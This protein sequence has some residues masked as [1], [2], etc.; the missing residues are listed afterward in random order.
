MSCNERKSRFLLLDK[1]ED[2]TATSFNEALVPG[3]GVLPP[4]LRRPSEDSR[5]VLSSFFVPFLF[6]FHCQNI[7]KKRK[8][9]S[10][11]TERKQMDKNN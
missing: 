6:H 9:W 1:V 3:L 11:F 4:E 2:K 5:H 8:K 7:A 10:I